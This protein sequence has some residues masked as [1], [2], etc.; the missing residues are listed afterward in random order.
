[1][2]TFAQRERELAHIEL[3][4]TDLSIITVR[5]PII[6]NR[7]KHTHNCTR[8]PGDVSPWRVLY[9]SILGCGG[10]AVCHDVPF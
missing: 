2:L 10:I 4:K 6:A 3:R 5:R 8:K 9:V 7:D 1:M